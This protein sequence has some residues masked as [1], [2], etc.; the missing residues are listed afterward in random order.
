MNNKRLVLILVV[1]LVIAIS[2]V[3]VFWYLSSQQEKK[4]ITSVPETTFQE[5]V[6]DIVP[7]NE[8]KDEVIQEK[9]FIQELS[10]AVSYTHLTLPTKRIV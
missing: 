5:E 10:A 8:V 2:L 1:L 6:A 3:G 7:Q 4:I 9:V